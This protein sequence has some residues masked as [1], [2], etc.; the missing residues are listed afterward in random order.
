MVIIMSD[1]TWVDGN[2]NRNYM[3]ERPFLYARVSLQ[4]ARP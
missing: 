4:T 2:V 3:Q 1:Y